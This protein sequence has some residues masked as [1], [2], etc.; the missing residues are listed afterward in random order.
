MPPKKYTPNL[1][2]RSEGGEGKQML[3]VRIV[4]T[5]LPSG[6]VLVI[7]GAIDLTLDLTNLD[8]EENQKNIIRDHLIEPGNIEHIDRILTRGQN[9]SPDRVHI[10]IQDTLVFVKEDDTE[11]QNS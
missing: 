9:Q 3:L 7:D 10:M 4:V 5:R 6:K 1:K 11:P 2:T 8:V